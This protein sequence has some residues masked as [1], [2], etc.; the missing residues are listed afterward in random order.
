MTA[1]CTFAFFFFWPKN[2]SCLPEY[3]KADTKKV[4]CCSGRDCC[5]LYVAWQAQQR[6]H[7]LA[8]NTG[9]AKLTVDIMNFI[10][11]KESNLKQEN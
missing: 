4:N 8:N 10:F 9:S 3:T 5:H 2:T 6:K 1:V 7:N 11:A